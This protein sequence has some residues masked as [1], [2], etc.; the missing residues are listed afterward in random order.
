MP[1][2]GLAEDTRRFE[3]ATAISPKAATR[4]KLRGAVEHT[5]LSSKRGLLDRLFTLAFGGLVYAQIWEDPVIDMEALAIGP[6]DRIVAIAS[7]GCNVLSYLTAAPEAITAVDLNR[8]HVALNRLKL[9]AARHLP[10]HAHFRRFFGDAD[11]PQNIAVFDAHLKDVL[12]E[13]TRE[14]WT[15]RDWRGRR[16]IGYFARHL[17]RHGLLGLFIASGHALARFYRIK[18]QVMLGATSLAEQRRLFEQ[19][20]APIFSKR[21]VRWLAKRPA[22]LFGLGIPPAQYAALLT[23][24][25]NG[26]GMEG[27]LRDRLARLAC[28]FP[29]AE[30]YFAWQAFGRAYGKAADAPLPPYLQA[31]N[32]LAVKN[33]AARVSV[34]HANFIEHLEGEADASLDCYVLLDAQDWMTD[35]ILTRLWTEITRTARPGAR[36]IFR[37]AA[38]ETLLPG[39]IPADILARWSYD[40]DR[41]R[42]WTAR[43]R[44]SIYGGFHLYTFGPAESER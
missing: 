38:E 44:S 36:V 14:Y 40:A 20:L 6:T 35:D 42:A 8:H 3:R 25:R 31:G 41:C 5:D 12:D 37:T 23:S 18:P 39:R 34:R 7:G 33:H 1:A 22:A 10:D 43:D 28:D 16:R 9:A 2:H 21:L 11:L 27:V 30:N 29:V 32:Y 19:H 17:Y 13:S 24:A 4:A 26:E 15:G